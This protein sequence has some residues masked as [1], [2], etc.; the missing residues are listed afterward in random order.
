MTYLGISFLC[1]S[2]R[3]FEK[4]LVVAAVVVVVSAVIVVLDPLPFGQH[5]PPARRHPLGVI[6]TFRAWRFTAVFSAA[7]VVVVLLLPLS[8]VART[9]PGQTRYGPHCD[10]QQDSMVASQPM[11]GMYL[12]Y[13]EVCM[14][15]IAWKR[16]VVHRR[17]CSS[18]RKLFR[19][20]SAARGGP[21]VYNSLAPFV[22]G[23]SGGVRD[24]VE[25]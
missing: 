1:N 21:R 17:F 10:G 22:C 14:Y 3:R 6:P 18:P 8:C 7:A 25:F 13:F 20:C 11:P 24:T 5:R 9:V 16:F 19:W 12:Q 15:Q 2:L 23:L 4:F